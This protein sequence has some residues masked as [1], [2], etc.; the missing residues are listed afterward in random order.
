MKLTLLIARRILVTIPVLIGVTM[1][2]FAVSHAITG[3]PARAFA[4]PYA[5]QATVAA[6]RREWG[7]DRP[8]V[9]QYWTYLTQL[10]HGNLGTSVETHNSVL[11]DILLRLP[12]TLELAFFALLLM[13]LIGISLGIA[14]SVWR[15]RSPDFLAR[16][17]A[18]AGAAVPS[19]W[20]GLML[21][22]LFFSRLKW[23][24]VSGRLGEFTKPPHHITGFY[25][26]DS[27]VTA[28]WAVFGDAL[29]HLLLPGF[30]LALLGIA[31][32]TRMTRS[33]ML[34]V[35]E[36]DYIRAARARGI[37]EHNVVLKHALRNAMVPTVTVLGLLFG[38]MI[39]GAI[40]I[41]WVFSWP[42]I[43]TYAADAITNLDYTAVMG[44]TLTIA[45]IYLIANLLVDISYMILNPTLREA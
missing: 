7:L 14:A 3:D 21:Q 25:L 17:V 24:P 19:F 29:K 23:L 41:E 9:D 12:A 40:I 42:G 8:L 38:A 1:I 2:T 43:G 5:D 31:G 20:L 44:V 18:V 15:D 11:H 30:T 6:I 33:S 45:V 39:G 13:C 36:K 35:L 34:E 28:N 22:L 37:R 10:A 27:A 26:I 16:T 4:G 32:I